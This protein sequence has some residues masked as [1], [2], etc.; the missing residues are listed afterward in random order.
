MELLRLL[1][2]KIGRWLAY[3]D[4]CLNADSELARCQ[5]FWTFLAILLGIVCLLALAGVAVRFVLDRR[6]GPLDFGAGKYR[7]P[8]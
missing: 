1:D 3:A 8:S 4:S 7:K 6:K 2:L 5:P